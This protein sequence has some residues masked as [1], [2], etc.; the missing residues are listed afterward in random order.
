MAPKEI[1]HWWAEIPG[2]LLALLTIFTPYCLVK[3]PN[4]PHK[5]VWKILHGVIYGAEERFSWQFEPELCVQ[6]YTRNCRLSGHKSSTSSFA[7]QER[8]QDYVMSEDFLHNKRW[9]WKQKGCKQ[10]SVDFWVCSLRVE[11]YQLTQCWLH[12]VLFRTLLF[13]C[14]VCVG[15]E[16][17]RIQRSSAEN[18]WKRGWKNS[19]RCWSLLCCFPPHYSSVDSKQLLGLIPCWY[20]RVSVQ[21][22]LKK[23]S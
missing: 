16:I 5:C 15:Q 8:G 4:Q 22:E 10:C 20:I 14:D 23:I 7:I 9:T 17:I 18:L 6:K 1:L 2:V 3:C 21:L 12:G 19:P 13:T 11:Q